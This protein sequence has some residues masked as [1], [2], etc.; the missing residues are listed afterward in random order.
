L[1]NNAINAV[2]STIERCINDDV[3]DIPEFIPF[4]MLKEEIIN[5]QLSLTSAG[6]KR[7]EKDIEKLNKLYGIAED[8][9]QKWTMDA[10]AEQQAQAMAEQGVV[11]NVLTQEAQMTQAP[12]VV[13]SNLDMSAD[14]AQMGNWNA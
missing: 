1:T 3:F 2:L 5:T 13:E 6:Y 4:Q 14:G 12:Q 10:Q 11:Q 8:M 9:E 7:N